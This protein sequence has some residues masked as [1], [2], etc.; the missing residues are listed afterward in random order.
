MPFT[1]TNLSLPTLVCRVKAALDR[2]PTRADE[3]HLPG[4]GVGVVPLLSYVGPRH[5]ILYYSGA[6]PLRA[7]LSATRETRLYCL[8]AEKRQRGDQQK[9]I[10]LCLCYQL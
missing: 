3:L 8:Y 5:P 2:L 10:L 6:N 4:F 7:A 1:H 9:H